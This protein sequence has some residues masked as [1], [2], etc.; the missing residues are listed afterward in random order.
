KELD[1]RGSS[2]C[3]YANSARRM[4]LSHPPPSI[5]TPF[6]FPQLLTLSATPDYISVLLSLKPQN[7]T[8]HIFP[9]LSVIVMEIYPQ[10]MLRAP[11][12]NFTIPCALSALMSF[13]D[14]TH[15]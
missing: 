6:T 14:S 3:L 5:H 7:T 11:L 15:N 13:C 9:N 4:S 8:T 10:D 2:P 12:D 1:L